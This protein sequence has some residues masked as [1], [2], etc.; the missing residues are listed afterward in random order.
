MDREGR[1]SRD[2]NK[3]TNP[4]GYL[5]TVIVGMESRIK[6]RSRDREQE[7]QEEEGGRSRDLYAPSIEACQRD[8]RRA[9]PAQHPVDR[10]PA[11]V[12]QRTLAPYSWG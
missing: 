11:G 7:N 6:K 4:A 12:A 2:N 8:Q 9:R 10:R 5:K 3:Y 1:E